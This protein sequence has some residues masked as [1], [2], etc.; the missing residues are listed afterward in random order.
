MKLISYGCENYKPFN[1]KTVIEVKPLTLIYGKNS[2][3]KSAILRL[4]RLILRAVGSRN[5]HGFPLVVD[6]LLFGASFNDLV[7]GRVL[8]GSATF[9]AKF[10]DGGSV[11]DLTVTVQE[12]RSQDLRQPDRTV[13]SSF[14]LT[15]PVDIVLD[16][17]LSP[18]EIAHY[19]GVGAVP[20]H[21]IL[22]S[23]QGA[24]TPTQ[25]Q[26]I[27]DWRE[28]ILHLEAAL[29]HVG[30]IRCPIKS[31][32]QSGSREMLGFDGAGAP[33]YLATN[34][35]L[36]DKTS[37]WYCDNMDGWRLAVDPNGFAFRCNLMQGRS[38]VNLADAGQGMQQ[39]LPIVVQQLAHQL[40]DDGNF[41]DL[42]EQPELHLHTAAQAPLGD[43][44]LETAKL[45]RGNLI[46]ETHSENVLLR[47]RRRIAEG[48]DPNLV[49]VYWVEDHPAGHSSMRRINIDAAG[50]L[51]WWRE[52]VF[53]EGYEEVRAIGRAA[54]ARSPSGQA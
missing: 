12:L 52:G 49:A 46:V 20:F 25:W 11:F 5:Q 42:I 38:T 14:N 32:Y 3:G 7:H 9:Y 21:G 10:E 29:T 37:M 26:V 35:A 45:D 36:L 47:I 39:V 50:N 43:L 13:I 6:G 18:N 4:L 51:D 19:R 30:P 31:L 8:H 44:F 23:A 54:R 40:E 2:S 34:S 22:P 28:R 17:E 1:Q 33:S 53:S 16:W 41:I 48:A 15:S 27:S 24:L